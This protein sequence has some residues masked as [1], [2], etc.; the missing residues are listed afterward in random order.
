MSLQALFYAYFSSG[1]RE[2]ISVDFIDDLPFPLNLSQ[3]VRIGIAICIV[4][5]LIGGLLLKKINFDYLRSPDTHLN[6]INL[7]IWVDQLNS[8]ILG[9]LNLTFGAI[10]FIFPEPIS[11][12]L[13]Q[14][15]CDWVP[16]F[17]CLNVTGSI[18]WR[19]QL[20][21]L[22]ILFIKAQ[23]WVKSTVIQDH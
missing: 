7:L 4:V 17:G 10:A 14:G 16:L 23:D 19:C 3:N 2:L 1:K 6:P 13:G 18:I 22:R 12:I 11:K 15:F 21:V 5:I 8:L 20:A 9:S